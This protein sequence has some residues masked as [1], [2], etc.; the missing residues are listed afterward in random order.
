ASHDVHGR[1]GE[2]VGR[3]HH[4]ADVR[5]VPEVLDGDV[6]RMAAG[7][8]VGDD[9]LAPP[10]PVGVDDVAAVPF[11]E[12]LRVQ[13]RVL[14]RRAGVRLAPRSDAYRPRVPLGGSGLG[15]PDPG[16]AGHGGIAIGGRAI[17]G[18]AIGGRAIGG[19]GGG[20]FRFRHAPTVLTPR[21][22]AGPRPHVRKTVAVAP[23]A[24]SARPGKE[25]AVKPSRLIAR[26]LAPLAITLFLAGMYLGLSRPTL[27]ET[28]LGA[29]QCASAFGTGSVPGA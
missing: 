22:A 20:V 2:R 12:Q 16:T 24:V 27:V 19:V 8:D 5:V 14:R 1:D 17:G 13:A 9:R 18:R 25:S 29:V 23:S 15:S 21:P 11:G 6:Q 4:G 7:V 28:S 3:A 26:L 10:V